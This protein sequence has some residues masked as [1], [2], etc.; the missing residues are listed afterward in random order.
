[1]SRRWL[2][3][4][5]MAT[6]IAGM[7]ALPAMAAHTDQTDPND[8]L[9]VLDVAEVRLAHRD[10]PPKWTIV[11]YGEWRPRQLWDRGYM[12]VRLDTRGSS[13]SDYYV[14]VRA[15]RR[16]I[17]GTMYRDYAEA[18]DRPI[19]PVSVWRPD[20]R[21]VRVVIPLG[22]LTFGS[23]RTSYWWSV[24]TLFTSATCP[25]TCF[26]MVP[27]AGAVEQALPSPSPT[28][29]PTASSSISSP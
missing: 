23:T 16:H 8:T 11:T 4:V 9:G 26:D 15:T 12:V 29:S 27:D 1:M 7:A 24:L 28:P 21:S 14:I 19:G 22:L 20:Q 25:R 3:G 17:V 10:D 6:V 13:A 5:A 18:R 2:V